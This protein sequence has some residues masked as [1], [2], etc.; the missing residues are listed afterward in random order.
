MRFEVPGLLDECK[1]AEAKL[2]QTIQEKYSELQ[3]KCR[4]FLS[5]TLNAF[6]LNA[7]MIWN[8]P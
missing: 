8:C 2:L 5:F 7:E 3:C 4:L 6:L 1:G